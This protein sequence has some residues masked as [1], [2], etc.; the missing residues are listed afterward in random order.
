MKLALSLALIAGV[1]TSLLQQSPSFASGND[2]VVSQATS[3]K[4]PSTSLQ[5]APG[6][7]TPYVVGAFCNPDNAGTR[8]VSVHGQHVL[9]MQAANQLIQRA[10][11]AGFEIYTSNAGVNPG[12]SFPTTSSTIPPGL[13]TFTV[14][15]LAKPCSMMV[16]SRNSDGAVTT[17]SATVS[18]GVNSVTPP[19]V[20]GT[21]T[22]LSSV[23]FL[24]YRALEPIN[25]FSVS[26]FSIN[27]KRIAIDP[28]HTDDGTKASGPDSLGN[29]CNVVG[30]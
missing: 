11:F 13:Y 9:T 23:Y 15:G 30:F 19:A 24:V 6:A 12:N 18:N 8:V 17:G 5:A 27:K 1:A 20:L 3:A 21:N 10:G 29:W 7:T 4:S 26:N 25:S 16:L 2:R 28:T 22:H 14:S